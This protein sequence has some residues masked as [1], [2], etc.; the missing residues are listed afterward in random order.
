MSS[1]V[2]LFGAVVVDVGVVAAAAVVVV[3]VVV[4]AVVVPRDIP[5]QGLLHPGYR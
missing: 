2:C 5:H 1:L 3:V 4:V